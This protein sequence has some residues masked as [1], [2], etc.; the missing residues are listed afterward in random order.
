MRR[1]NGRPGAGPVGRGR[2]GC[3]PPLRGG[4]LRCSQHRLARRNSLRSLR[5]LRSNN[6]RE[7]DGRCAL[8]APPVL[9]R[10]SAAHMARPRPTAQAPGRPLGRRKRGAGAWARAFA[11]SVAV[12]ARNGPV[13]ARNATEVA[14]AAGGSGPQPGRAWPGQPP[15]GGAPGGQAPR[16]ALPGA[17]TRRGRGWRRVPGARGPPSAAPS[18]AVSG[19]AREARFVLLTCGA[20]FERSSRSERSELRRTTPRRAAEGSRCEA[21]TAAVSG[22]RAPG[23]RRHPRPRRVSAPGSALRGA[24][25]PGA[26]PPGGWPGHARPGCGPL[27][28]AATRHGSVG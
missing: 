7:N 25:P 23:T 28:P 3:L 14:F 20:L 5:E 22:P 2:A 12:F 1:P 9:L 24:W 26:P 19:S 13:F 18:S 27:P 15:G 10:F 11:I 8:R 4:A 6:R 21:P 16:R 17:E